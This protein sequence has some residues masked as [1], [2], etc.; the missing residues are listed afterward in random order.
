MSGFFA[1]AA[2]NASGL[3]VKQSG[4]LVTKTML[5]VLITVIALCSNDCTCANLAPQSE[6]NLPP[7]RTTTYS[8]ET[9]LGSQSESDPE[10]EVNALESQLNRECAGGGF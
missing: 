10:F 4:A 9:G 3:H 2:S 8:S 7:I 6:R 1:T 5:S